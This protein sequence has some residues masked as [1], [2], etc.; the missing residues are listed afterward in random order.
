VSDQNSPPREN[1]IRAVMPGVELRAADDDDEGKVL[2]GHFSRFN[3]WTEIDSM[4]EGHFME[5]F[6]PGAF[7]KTFQESRDRMRL[8]FQHGMD[9]DVGDKPIG[10]IDQLREDDEGGYYEAR[11]FDG[12]PPLVLDG[13]R[14]GQYGASM[15]F[16]VM[17]DRE[18]KRPERSEHNPD[19][20]AERTIIEA[21]VREFGP[22]TFPA[23]EGATAGVRSLTDDFIRSCFR[24][25]PERLREM[26][27]SASDVEA[28][29]ED[30]ELQDDSAARS[31][32]GT[33]PEQDAPS[34]DDAE[35][36]AHLSDERRE[37]KPQTKRP[38]YGQRR[39]E[40]SQPWLLGPLRSTKRT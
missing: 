5:R 25:N 11:L 3:E 12:L 27:A 35:P 9:P 7:R 23:Y 26:F 38:I 14:A 1:L 21:K 30:V 33:E 17:R 39:K 40:T 10:T 37:D 15:R 19:G 31:D 20:L 24:E 36:N 4:W 22:V 13:L 2:F 28:P 34:T 6:A 32:T 16:S 29:D 18:D 8:L